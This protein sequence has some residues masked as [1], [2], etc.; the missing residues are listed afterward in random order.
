LEGVGGGFLLYLTFFK[1]Q[2]ILLSSPYPL[3]R[4]TF[5]LLA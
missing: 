1:N 2:I 5:F 3:Q 4:G